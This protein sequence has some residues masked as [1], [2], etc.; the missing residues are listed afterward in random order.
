MVKRL[1]IIGAG[2]FIGAIARHGLSGLVQHRAGALFPAGTLVVNVVGCALLGALLAYVETRPAL[3]PDSRAFLTVGILGSFTTF[4]TFG[5]ET[6]ELA[7]LG[8][9][10]L[11]VGNVAANVAAGLVA[12]W[13]GRLVARLMAG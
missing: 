7:R 2:G 8:A 13:L 4:S 10:R 12:L 11:A 9:T 6:L 5:F 1:L 3:D